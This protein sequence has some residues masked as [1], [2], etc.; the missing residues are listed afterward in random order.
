MQGKRYIFLG[1]VSFLALLFLLLS[2]ISTPPGGDRYKHIMPWRDTVL[3]S[4]IIS[5]IPIPE[6]LSFAGEEVP[7]QYF[8]VREALDRELQVNTFWH[9]QTVL[10]LKRANRFF[11]VIEPI[12]KDQGVPDD[13]KYL[14]VAESGLIQAISPAKAVGFW[15][16]LETT[17]KEYGLEVNKE[18]DERCHIEKSTVAACKYF[19]K[20]YVNYG[21]WT[22]AAASYN[23]GQNGITRQIDRQ[24]SNSYYNM[25][26]GEETG[27]YVF[28]IL[29]LKVIFE[30]PKRYGFYLDDHDLYPPFE[31]S[32]VNVDTAI[33][34]IAQ[35][36]QQLGT[37]YKMVKMLNP[38]LR[39]SYLPKRLNKTYEIKILKQ[40]F[41]EGAYK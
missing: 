6:K 29:A 19:K 18:V 27:R 12:L 34:S 10:L 24:D 26:L 31:Y 11:P 23:F 5:P 7:L 28:R 3:Q 36:A 17:A 22:M 9:S 21:S 32:E 16:L 37:N 33:N 4:A 40:G 25:I 13:F 30:N 8:D 41:R 35:F 20:A 14:A 1:L 38:W 15:Q 2:F 39:E